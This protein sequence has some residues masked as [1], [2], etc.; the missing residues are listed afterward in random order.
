M[1]N[2][3]VGISTAIGEAAIHMVRMSGDE[4]V[5][6]A[7]SV[8]RSKQKVSMMK[9]HTIAYGKIH[10]LDD[11][12]I[13]EVLLSVFLPPRTYT[14]EPVVEISCHGGIRVMFEIYE[15]LQKCGARKAEAGEFTKRAFLNGRIDLTQAEAVM[16]VIEAE[17]RQ[18]LRLANANLEGRLSKE[19]LQLQEQVLSII[20]TIE[21]NIDYP[22]YDDVEEMTQTKILEP[23]IT[24]QNQLHDLIQRA[25]GGKKVNDG[26][27]V[28][29]VGRPNVGK[30]SILNMLLE[31]NKAIVT[32][33]AGTTRDIVEGSLRLGP[34][35]LQLVD[36]AGIR[37]T[38]DV[39][40]KIGV[41]RSKKAIEEAELVLFVLSQNEGFTEEDEQL[42]NLMN[43]KKVITLL[44]KSDQNR[45]L[46]H[47]FTDGLI[48]SAKENE[49]KTELVERLSFLYPEFLETSAKN[50]ILANERQV[51][52]LQQSEQAIQD[53][54][55]NALLGDGLDLLIVPLTEA[56]SYLGEITGSISKD[57]LLDELF[58]KFCLG[59]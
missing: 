11:T 5:K 37:E 28:A 54:I 12:I 59:K 16:G 18:T 53:T 29:L 46:E 43:E 26:I 14:K 40:E 38:D 1:S 15:L 22:E 4:A 21:V 35:K 27:K 39:V 47:V 49:G 57:G 41:E 36:T 8:F 20:A 51:A 44:N 56:W 33:I 24:F 52:L 45:G 30:S 9:S 2:T 58:S 31:E 34:F 48:F 7:D 13:D 50:Q 3:I 10:D 25:Q 6:I 19:I 32:E 55:Q 42:Q 17:S 23:L